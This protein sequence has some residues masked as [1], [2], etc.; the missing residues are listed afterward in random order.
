ML[1]P[2]PFLARAAS[3]DDI[4]GWGRRY[5]PGNR[6]VHPKCWPKFQFGIFGLRVQIIC[7]S[8]AFEALP[9][10]PV[11]AVQGGAAFTAQ[12]TVRFTGSAGLGPLSGLDGF[13]GLPAVELIGVGGRG[14][15]AALGAPFPYPECWSRVQFG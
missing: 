1:V 8:G 11:C 12:G 3:V 15:V 10:P 4:S 2:G 5:G 9:C 7:G 14:A 13:G 6:K